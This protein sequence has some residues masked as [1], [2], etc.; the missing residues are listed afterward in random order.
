MATLIRLTLD[1][2][3]VKSDDSYPIVFRITH[4]RVQTTIKTSYS[5][6]E[7]YWDKKLSN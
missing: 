3:R 5:V 7:K 1:T 4:N 6:E 2:R